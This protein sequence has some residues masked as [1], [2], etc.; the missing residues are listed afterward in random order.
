[1]RMLWLF[2]VVFAVPAAQAAFRCVDEKGVTHIGDTPPAGCAKVPM[3]EISRTGTV[4]RKIDPT[5]T[6][7]ELKKKLEEQARIREEEK[8]RS[9]QKRRDWALLSTYASERDIDMSRDTSIEPVN[10]RIRSARERIVAVEKRQQEL[11]DEMEFYKAGK[12]KSTK[13]REAPPQLVADL[14]RNRAEHA[15]L[16]KSIAGYEREIVEL[17]AKFDVDKRRWSALKKGQLQPGMLGGPGAVD[18]RTLDEKPPEPAKPT[19]AKAAAKK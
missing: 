10:G 7:E 9:E 6:P 8:L 19:E 14:E 5:P 16:A 12:S 15:A 4:L 17:K 2:L 18:P 1:M 11:E 3:Y 13:V